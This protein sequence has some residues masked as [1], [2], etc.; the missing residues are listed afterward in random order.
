VTG[1]TISDITDNSITVTGAELPGGH[2]QTVIEYAYNTAN[3]PPGSGWQT[4]PVFSGL[5]HGTLYYIFARSQESANYSAGTAAHVTATTFAGITIN[6][7]DQTTVQLSGNIEFTL[8]GSNVTVTLATSFDSGTVWRVNDVIR[9]GN[10]SS[11]TLTAAYFNH[12][13][14]GSNNTLYVE[15][16][17]DGLLY[18]ATI[19]F[20]VFE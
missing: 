16:I 4:S 17:R 6:F 9:S 12:T 8:G 15:G 20:T 5:N 2:E 18:S 11:L 3:T 14:V 19:F 13:H 7:T 10:N 1:L